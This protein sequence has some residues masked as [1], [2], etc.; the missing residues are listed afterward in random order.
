MPLYRV[1]HHDGADRVHGPERGAQHGEQQRKGG[2]R[3]PRRNGGEKPEH[4]DGNDKPDDRHAH[5]V[6]E[7]NDQAAGSSEPTVVPAMN[8]MS[9]RPEALAEAPSTT[10]Q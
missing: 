10:W 6:R 5:V 3:K 7:P 8:A 1:L 9:T 2:E 4:R